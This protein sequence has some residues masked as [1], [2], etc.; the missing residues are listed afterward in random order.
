M[1]NKILFSFMVAVF[2]FLFLFVNS[3]QILAA[4]DPSEKSEK[5]EM[6]ESHLTPLLKELVKKTKEKDKKIPIIITF[7]SD[8]IRTHGFGQRLNRQEIENE[9]KKQANDSQSVVLKYLKGKEQA[10]RVENIHSSWLNNS[11]SVKA[12]KDVIQE[13]GKR[14]DLDE[15]VLDRPVEIQQ[16]KHKKVKMDQN[17]SKETAE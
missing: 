6:E 3:S 14:E 13:L 2:V 9:L 15:I 8:P 7:K 4:K 11:I 10:K 16:K 1:K 5:K 12:T 17:K